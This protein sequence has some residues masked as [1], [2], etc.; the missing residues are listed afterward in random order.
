MAYDGGVED[1]GQRRSERLRE[2]PAAPPGACG[3]NRQHRR[4]LAGG[5]GSTAERLPEEP[6]TPPSTCARNQRRRPAFARGTNDVAQP[7]R[8]ETTTPPGARASNRWC[9][10]KGF[11]GHSNPSSVAL[12]GEEKCTVCSV[13]DQGNGKRL[14]EEPTVG[15]QAT[16]ARASRPRPRRRRGGCSRNAPGRRRRDLCRRLLVSNVPLRELT[17]TRCEL[18]DTESGSGV[19]RESQDNFLIDSASK[20]CRIPTTWQCDNGIKSDDI[21]LIAS[22][23]RGLALLNGNGYIPVIQCQGDMIEACSE[24]LREEPMRPPSACARNQ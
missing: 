6:A 7:L 21:N 20:C 13:A 9:R 8:A 5:T 2:E 11:F 14:R 12:Q 23:P 15:C 1:A 22:Q 24:R 4:A 18:G 17:R 16:K 3:R 19:A 10:A